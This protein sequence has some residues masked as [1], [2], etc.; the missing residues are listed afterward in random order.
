[1]LIVGLFLEIINDSY[2]PD[3]HGLLCVEH[4]FR[5]IF[6]FLFCRG[7]WLLLRIKPNDLLYFFSTD[8]ASL[9]LRRTIFAAS[10]MAAWD[11]D[12]IDV[13]ISF[14]ANSTLS[15]SQFNNHLPLSQIFVVPLVNNLNR[16][17]WLVNLIWLLVS[18]CSFY[19]LRH[20]SR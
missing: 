11:K 12:I 6:G 13:N 4:I 20:I 10:V 17:I 14:Q 2:S 8:G 15:I 18:L 3:M 1:M 9:T 16:M 19:L 5:L 7:F